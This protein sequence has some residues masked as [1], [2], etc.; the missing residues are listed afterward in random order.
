[1]THFDRIIESV[2]FWFENGCVRISEPIQ[3]ERI[4]SFTNLTWSLLPL[5][6]GCIFFSS[7][8]LVEMKCSKKWSKWSKKYDFILWISHSKNTL[9]KHRCLKNVP[10]LNIIHF[11]PQT[12]SSAQRPVL[13]WR[14]QASKRA[15]EGWCEKQKLSH[16]N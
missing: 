14:V 12:H 3:Q 13:P 9:I 10:P 6:A 2:S 1:M 4:S 8:W 11:I 5:R 16:S 7:W 15:N